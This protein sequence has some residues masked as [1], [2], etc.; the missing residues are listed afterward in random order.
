MRARLPLPLRRRLAAWTEHSRFRSIPFIFTASLTM[1][2]LTFVVFVGVVLTNKFSDTAEKNAYLSTQQIVDQI[3]NNLGQYLEAL[4]EIFGA[5]EKEM[6]ASPSIAD[7]GLTEKLN[8]IIG[9]RRDIVSLALFT[10][11]GELVTSLPYTS[12]RKNTELTDQSWFGLA[13]EHPDHLTLTPPHI[14]NLFKGQY[15]WVVSMSKGFTFSQNGKAVKGVLLIDTNFSRIDELCRNIAL[16]RKG[17][18]YLLDA[19]GNV[20]YHP[21]QQL[22]YLGLKSENIEQ[23]INYSYGRYTDT[24]DGHKRLITISPVRDTGWKVV[25]VSYLNEVFTARR[26]LSGYILALFLLF[27]ALILAISAYLSAKITKPMKRLEKSMRLV[28]KGD[29]NQNVHVDGAYEV[30]QLSGRFG[31]ML[32]RIRE[33]LAQNARDQETRRKNELEVL[34]AQINPHFL[35]NTLNSVVRMA[36]SGRNDEVVTT[37]TSLSKF[38]RISLSKGK[39]VIPLSDELE[40]VRHYLIIQQLRFR[41]KFVFDIRAEE[42]I[43]YAFTLKLVLQPI[44]ENAIHHGI[45]YLTEEGRIL[46]TA[47]AENGDLV[48]RV[49]DNGVGMDEQRLAEVRASTA[50]SATG[51]GVG[52]RNVAERIR[53]AYGKAYG[54]EIESEREIGTTVTLRM[55]LVKEENPE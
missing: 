3:T 38:F 47:G 52:I 30:E 16:G 10:K 6:A 37:I 26:E 24:L 19:V 28:E 11:D 23:A 46:I 14:Q 40:H 13:L 54:L 48:L 8:T 4:E 55:P 2:T 44:A 1:I 34:Q 9:T 22:L 17:Y 31:T 51:S 27:V 42:G 12:L 15:P 7:A 29:L 5:A 36:G 33:L 45:E 53:L 49:S 25:G 43:E 39:A 50:E 18:V 20:V 41:G 32:G 35:Y 21:Q